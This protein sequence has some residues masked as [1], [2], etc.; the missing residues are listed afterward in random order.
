MREIVCND[1]GDFIVLPLFDGLEDQNTGEVVFESLWVEMCLEYLVV[2]V[3]RI[4]GIL[5]LI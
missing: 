5:S 2:L 1:D 4:K 3:R